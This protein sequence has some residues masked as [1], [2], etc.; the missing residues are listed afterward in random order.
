M[1]FK[2]LLW[3]CKDMEWSSWPFDDAAEL[4]HFLGATRVEVGGTKPLSGKIMTQ[5]I[6][7]PSEQK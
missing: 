2:Y 5:Q 3:I 6:F 4:Y 1:R 7:T